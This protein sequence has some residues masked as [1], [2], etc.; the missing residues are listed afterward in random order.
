MYSL[1][2]SYLI[3]F[4]GVTVLFNFLTANLLKTAKLFLF[5]RRMSDLG[6]RNFESQFLM[7]LGL[8]DESFFIHY[9]QMSVFGLETSAILRNQRNLK[10]ESKFRAKGLYLKRKLFR[11]YFSQSTSNH[12]ASCT[13]YYRVLSESIW[14][15]FSNVII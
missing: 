3:L 7:Y 2:V 4:S 10:T 1:H 15:L 8:D 13:D 14:L 6:Y 11:A 5:K 12:T 9:E